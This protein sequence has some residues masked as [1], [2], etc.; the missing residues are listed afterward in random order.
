MVHGTVTT[1]LN[2]NST[3]SIGID[4]FNFDLKPWY[5]DFTRNLYT[6]V[7]RV[8]VGNGTPFDVY[9]RGTVSVAP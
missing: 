6:L 4:K 2:P 8:Y 1:K 3:V 7:L 5:E 9:F